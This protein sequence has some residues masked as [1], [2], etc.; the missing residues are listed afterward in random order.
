VKLTI[1]DGAKLTVT[2][3]LTVRVTRPARKH[4]RHH[5]HRAP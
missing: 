4:R 2:R 3:T 1:T 5:K